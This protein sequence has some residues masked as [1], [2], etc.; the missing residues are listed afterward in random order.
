MK[1]LGFI[2]SCF[3]FF[4]TNLYGQLTANPLNARFVTDDVDRFWQALDSL[5]TGYKGNPFQDLYIKKGSP[6]VVGFMQ[7]RI[8]NAD[9][10]LE[11]VKRDKSK[12]LEKKANSLNFLDYKKQCLST[13]MALKFLYPK[14]VFPPVYFVVGR[15]N[16]GGHSD[17]SGLIIGAE[18]NQAD[19]AP[20]IVAHELIHFQQDSIK[21]GTVNLLMACIAEGSA[22]FIGELISGGGTNR[23]TYEFGN[24]N[25]KRLW[26]EFKAIMYDKDNNHGW[27][28]NYAPSNGNPPDLG[29]WIGYKITE[30]YYKNSTDKQKAISDIL[31]I[32]DYN[33][34]L[35]KSHYQDKFK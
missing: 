34:F 9:S 25:E 11:S 20:F 27:M 3:I 32:K 35:R 30:S 21:D 2:S 18:M 22:D 5:N 16:S 29:Y 1:K 7:A 33:E 6:G 26:T 15:F 12:Y 8:V 4:I 13:F 31:H 28:Y 17:K 23:K 24:A 10:L 14:A 19:Q